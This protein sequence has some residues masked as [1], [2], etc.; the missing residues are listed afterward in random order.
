MFFSGVVLPTLFLELETSVAGQT[1][2][3]LF[4]GYYAFG[5]GTGAVVL[6]ASAALA[7]G[8]QGAWKLAVLAVVLAFAC[9]LYAGLSIRPRMA[10]L[11]GD[12]G[13]VTEFQALHRLSV[14]LNT[15]VLLSTIGVLCASGSLLRKD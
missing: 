10:A 5:I 1:A 14:R 12:P 8:G 7:R 11:R 4:P 3:L 6:V 15:I 2:A 9:Q 13:G